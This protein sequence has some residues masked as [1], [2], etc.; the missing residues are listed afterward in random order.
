MKLTAKELAILHAKPAEEPNRSKMKAKKQKLIL[1]R[2]ALV[3][4][5]K[6]N[7]PSPKVYWQILREAGR[8][9]THCEGHGCGSDY[10]LTVHHI[11]GNPHNNSLSNLR[12]LCWDCH[13]LQHNNVESGV[14]DELEGTKA[15]M[16]NLNDPE[17]RAFYGIVQEDDIPLADDDNLMEALD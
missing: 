15:D 3:F 1:P 2:K 16:D 7:R 11:D 14:I 5:V 17:V 8:D 6:S 13:L 10:K 12:I 9:T 4:R